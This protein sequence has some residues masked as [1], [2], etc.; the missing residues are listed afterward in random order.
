MLKAL[1]K[2]KL[3]A[4][5]ALV[6]AAI[7]AGRAMTAEEQTQYNDLGVEINNLEAT[8]KAADEMAQQQAAQ[9]TPAAP[10]IFAQPKD[11]NEKKWKGGMGEFLK[12]VANASQPGGTM[13]TRLTYQNAAS[14][15][16]EAVGSEGGFLLETEFISGMQDAMMAETQVANRIRQIPISSKTN[17]LR[18]LGVD[19]TSR[20]NGSRWGGVLAYWLSEADTVTANKPK[21]REIDMKLEKLMAL[22][23][24]T[25]ELLEDASALEAIVRQAYADEMSFKLDD[26]IINGLGV[27]MPLGILNAPAL[28]SVAKEAG[29]AAGTILYDN[30]LKM[31]A[32]MPARNRANAVWYINQEA[33]PQLYTMSL[34]IGTGGVPVYMPAGGAAGAQF[35]SLFT[36]PVVPIEQCQK[37]GDKGDIILADPTQYIGIDKNNI[38][39]DVSIHVRFVYAESLFRFMYRFNGQPYRTSPITPYKG[40]ANFK[41]SPF[42]SLDAR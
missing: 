40:S 35:S 27:G 41:L 7:D 28:V 30:V 36:R 3:D 14:G 9:N 1:L 42:V 38:Q 31:W 24:V 17:R 16:N 21:F 33:E 26:S 10:I 11:P 4:R 15:A 32:R 8:I 29:Q 19:E 25:D 23:Y 13:D 12:A 37:L 5:A 20:A 2:T 34:T 22:C 18:A 39:S 6:K